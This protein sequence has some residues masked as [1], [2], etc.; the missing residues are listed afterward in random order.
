VIVQAPALQEE[1]IGPHPKPARKII[2]LPKAK[3]PEAA[4]TR[5]ARPPAPVPAPKAPSPQPEPKR[6]PARPALEPRM[7]AAR[8]RRIARDAAAAWLRETYPLAFGDQV[9][10]LAIGVGAL[11]WPVAKAA[12]IK[13]RAYNDAILRRVNSVLYRQALAEDGAVRFDL[14]GNPAEPV[15][16]DHQLQALER[17]MSTS[18]ASLFGAEKHVDHMPA[19]TGPDP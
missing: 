16:A 14:D 12:G 17:L 5:A 8:A 7:L 6:P 1:L 19:P 15:S 2:S 9:R 13:R 10:P 3:P 18:P 4:P 11:I